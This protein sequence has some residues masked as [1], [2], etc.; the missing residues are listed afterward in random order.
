MHLSGTIL[1]LDVNVLKHLI[2]MMGGVVSE[3]IT[4]CSGVI[5]GSQEDA[6]VWFN[7]LQSSSKNSSYAKSISKSKTKGI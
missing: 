2:N 1:D 7:T 4:A 6:N 5:F 3:D